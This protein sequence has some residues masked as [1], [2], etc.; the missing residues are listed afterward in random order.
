VTARRPLADLLGC[1]AIVA[2]G[3]SGIGHAVVETMAAAGASVIVVDRNAEAAIEVAA[4]Q[5]R[6]GNKATA[7]TLDVTDAGAA[8]RVLGEIAADGPIS[9]LVNCVG[10]NR[11][12]ELE[13]WND[14]DWDELISVNLTGAWNLVSATRP[15]LH[16]TDASIVLVSSVAG[17]SGIP[18]AAPYTA[19][20]HGIVG[21]TRALALD[22]GSR[23]VTV[24]AICPGVIGTPLLLQATTETFRDQAME[25]TPLRR[26]GTPADVADAIVFLS[27]PHARWI[28]GAVIPVDGGLTCGI[29][30]T[31]WE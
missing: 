22:L 6:A 31:H 26:L 15:H 1:R 8:R 27:S 16:P 13:D 19:A 9:A 29:R 30:S 21:L 25:R 11:F 10:T 23:S 14:G 24:N 5:V 18:K 17:I 12:A 7:V 3:A 4:E 20:K 2:G 28:T